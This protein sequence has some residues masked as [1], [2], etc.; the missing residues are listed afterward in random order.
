MDDPNPT[1]M[2]DSNVPWDVQYRYFTKGWVNNW[3]WGN[4]DGTFAYNFFTKASGDGFLPAVQ[5]YQMVSEQPWPNDESK[6][7]A[8]LQTASTMKSYFSDFILFMKNVKNFGKPVLVLMEGD[9]FG[10]CQIQSNGNSSLYAAI[11]DSGVPELQ[12]LPNTVYG[13][14]LA[15]L[16]I[17]QATGATNAYMGIHISGWATLKDLFYAS[18]T[19]PMQPEIDLIYNFL[20]PFGLNKNN[21]VGDEFD[22][23][24]TD[25]L[26]RDSDFYRLTMN[27]NRWWD[28]ADSAS[29]NSQSF[30]RHIE[31]IRLFN[32]KSGKKFILWQIPLGN[33]NSKNV[34]NSNNNIAG[35]GYKDN[36]PEYFFGDGGNGICH[37]RK[38]AEAGVYALLFGRGEG[39][40]SNYVNDVYSDG[41]YFMKSRAKKNF[42]DV[43]GL[44]LNRVGN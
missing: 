3:G 40:Q 6:F 5:Y 28:A 34:D 44:G 16:K 22:F 36:R 25:P 30:N 24:V 9:G 19:D 38:Y 2:K 7:V 21:V 32:Q 1:W 31:Y 33:S 42:F 26:D 20:L 27:Q 4:Y 18:V 39:R 15:L 43:G 11:S 14:G 8:K 41:Q 29:I 13:F 12:G 35:E 17:R 10:F 37:C 23:M